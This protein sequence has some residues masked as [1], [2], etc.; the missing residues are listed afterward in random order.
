VGGDGND[1]LVGDLPQEID[2]YKGQMFYATAAD[3]VL[4]IFIKD[5]ANGLVS[6]YHS[7]TSMARGADYLYGGSGDDTLWGGAGDDELVGGS[8]SD[9]YIFNRGDGFDVIAE[10]VEIAPSNDVLVL[11]AGLSS[12]RTVFQRFEDDLILDWGAD[13]TVLITDQFSYRTTTLWAPVQA[14]WP[15]APS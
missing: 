3:S 7:D 13:G 12:A 5:F 6:T 4:N 8:G 1:R 14:C 11:G 10:D 2:A 9:T 15:Q